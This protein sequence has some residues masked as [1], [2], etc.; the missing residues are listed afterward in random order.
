MKP[1]QR[2]LASLVPRARASIEGAAEDTDAEVELA[3]RQECAAYRIAPGEPIVEAVSR[4][5]RAVGFQPTLGASGGGSDANT[6]N[7]KGFV[8]ST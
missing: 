6:F 5:V 3:I 4:A 1:E 2:E 7:E 8:A